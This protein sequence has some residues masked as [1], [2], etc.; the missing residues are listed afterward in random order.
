MFTVSRKARRALSRARDRALEGPMFEFNVDHSD[1]CQVVQRLL[2]RQSCD[3]FQGCHGSGRHEN[4]S[5]EA[6]GCSGVVRSGCA[7]EA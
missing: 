7:V 5:L 1:G 6:G 2:S 3:T 4:G